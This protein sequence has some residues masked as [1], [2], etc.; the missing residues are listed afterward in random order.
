MPNTSF[1]TSMNAYLIAADIVL[2]LHALFV[3]FVV[4]GLALTLAGGLL[5]WRWVRD[6]WFR[7]AHLAAIGVVVVQS[8]LG[9][10][11]PLTSLEM[12]LRARAGAATYAGSFVTHHLE[13][14]LYYRAP[15]WAFVV[16]YT[17]FAAAV[18]ASWFAVRPHGLGLLL[19]G[20]DDR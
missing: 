9:I 15:P 13:M 14:L 5:G 10:L 2:V 12:A 20:E 7:L 18:V 3:L 4:A 17:G 8:W 19:S 11:C 6:P 16:V 1:P